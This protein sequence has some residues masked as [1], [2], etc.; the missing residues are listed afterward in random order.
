[1]TQLMCR[2]GGCLG[3]VE[4]FVL[5]MSAILKTGEIALQKYVLGSVKRVQKKKQ[6]RQELLLKY[7][8]TA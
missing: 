4:K 7:K 6:H 5:K 3:L 2:Y 8:F 1:M